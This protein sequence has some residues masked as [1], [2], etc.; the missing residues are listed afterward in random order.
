ML[1]RFK[2]MANPEGRE[3]RD[4]DFCDI[5]RTF[6]PYLK[7]LSQKDGGP[8]ETRYDSLAEG[9]PDTP[10]EGFAW[11]RVVGVHDPALIAA[12]ARRFEL[13]P[14][15][16]EEIAG[17]GRRPRLDVEGDRLLLVLRLLSYDEAKKRVLAEQVSLVVG[18]GLLI[19]FQEQERDILDGLAERC[20]TG[21]GRFCR[22]GPGRLLV[23]MLEA[24][25]DEYMVTLGHLAEDIEE[26]EEELLVKLGSNSLVDIYRLKREVL[27]LHRSLW[28]LREILGRLTK[29]EVFDDGEGMSLRVSGVIQDSFQVIEAVETLREMLTEMLTVYMTKVDLRMGSIVRNLTVV[30]TIFLPLNFI[31][32]F[33]GMN[34]VDLPLLKSEGSYLGVMLAMCGIVGFMLLLFTRKRWIG[35]EMR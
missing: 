29:E 19:T 30:A 8:S 10:K 15:F 16:T 2:K 17:T 13:H 31:V 3:C 27:Y 12:V 7:V 9:Q 25:I 14:V 22:E 21:P 32:G 24:I 26:I 6:R 35:P 23:A 1:K 34:F 18:P 11:V 33:F 5:D 4:D 20:L 28:P